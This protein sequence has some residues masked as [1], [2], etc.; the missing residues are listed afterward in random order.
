MSPVR[1]RRCPN[2]AVVR[3]ASEFRRAGGPTGAATFAPRAQRRQQG[4]A[5]GF[6]GLLRAFRLAEPPELQLS[7]QLQSEHEPD[8]L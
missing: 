6:I 7:R 5:C 3:P 4:P 2:C 8:H 1:Y